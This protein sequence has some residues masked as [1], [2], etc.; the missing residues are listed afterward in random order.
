MIM[1]AIAGLIFLG[2]HIVPAT[3]LRAGAINA[4]GEGPYMGVFVVLSLATLFF[5]AWAFEQAPVDARAWYYPNWWPWLKAVIM[6][7]AFVLFVGG[8][9]SPNP[10]AVRQGELLERPDVGHGIFAITRHPLMWAFGIWGIAHLISEPNWR[11]FWFFGIFAI[12]ALGGAWLQERRKARAYG[13]AW[14]RF[15]AKTS[16]VPFVA[17]IQ[18]RAR[19]SL[20]EIGWWRVGLGV[21]LWAA[22]L[23][24]HPLLFGVSPLPGLRMG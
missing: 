9:A 16:F 13:A 22:I 14:Q 12:V 18:G 20:A 1:L 8:V 7:F 5:W 24:F 15:A 11:G 10:T 6:L 17:L 2:I 23:H 21:V 3:R 4:I 19:L